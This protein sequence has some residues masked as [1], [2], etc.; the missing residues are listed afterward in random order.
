MVMDTACSSGLDTIRLLEDIA[1]SNISTVLFIFLHVRVKP[2]TV[3][4]V[5]LDKFSLTSSLV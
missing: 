2:R 4:Q 3:E 5:F 1:K